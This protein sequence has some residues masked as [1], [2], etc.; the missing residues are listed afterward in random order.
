MRDWFKALW[1][2]TAYS[3]WWLLSAFSTLSTYAVPGMSARVRMAAALSTIVGFAWA[4]FRVFKKQEARILASHSKIALL[5][6]RTSQLKITVDDGSRY[7]LKPVGNVPRGDFNGI[8]LEFHLMIENSGRKNST[9]DRYEVEIVELQMSRPNLRPKEGQNMI[10]GR[11]CQFAL[12]PA[13]VL[14]TTG[15]VRI[16][17]ETA[18]NRGILLFFVP[19]VGL[20][21]FVNAGLHMNG[22]QRK[23][24]ALTCRLTLTDTSQ[25]SVTQ[26]FQLREE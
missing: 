5:E 26:E 10:Q 23:F 11:H 3:I 2:E 4:N 6:D 1:S 17:A 25:S 19:E 15:A 22:E 21:Q 16:G 9:I 18:T 20:Q 14:S 7:I 24:G 8:F 13:S 12:L